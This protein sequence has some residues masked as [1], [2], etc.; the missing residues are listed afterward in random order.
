MTVRTS[1][2]LFFLL[3]LL[4]VGVTAFGQG[5]PGKKGQTDTERRRAIDALF[6]AGNYKAVAEFFLQEY[7]KTKNPNRLFNIGLCYEKLNEPG[8]AVHYYERY[9]NE[10]PTAEDAGKLRLRIAKLKD[11][12]RATWAQIEFNST[13]KA[14]GVFLD[15]LSKGKT[16]L[17]LRL[18][19]NTYDFEIRM[20]GFKPYRQKVVAPKQGHVVVHAQLVPIRKMGRVLIDS[21]MAGAQLEVD[22]RAQGALKEGG[23][24][25]DLKA[26]KH[27]FKV[28]KKGH[29]VWQKT[30]ELQVGEVARLQATL[31]PLS[32]PP[33]VGERLTSGKA[34][35][36]WVSIGLAIAAEVSALVY[37][38]RAGEYASF[39]QEHEAYRNASIGLQ[40]A[41][42]LSAAA[43]I[44]LISWALLEEHERKPITTGTLMDTTLLKGRF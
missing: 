44:G 39:R 11:A 25:F 36:G 9:L 1:V 10:K 6:K 20:K 14:A 28:T 35:A 19:G 21:N 22:G 3:S 16:P 41:A 2:Q 12:Y 29:T 5:A 33:T 40:V 18:P 26:G 24:R 32:V 23:R 37:R 34:I 38:D 7:H 42:G 8:Q 27:R 17:A 43:G 30:F 13:P 15:D 31:L 4:C